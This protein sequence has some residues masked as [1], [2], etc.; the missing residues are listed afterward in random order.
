MSRSSE[1]KALLRA[2]NKRYGLRLEKVPVSEWPPTLRLLSQQPVEV[3]RS[4]GYLVQ[5][6]RAC[7]G[8]L[9]LSICTTEIDGDRWAD[10]ISWRRLQRLKAECGFGDREAVEIY[11]PDAD[12]VDVANMRHLW[13]LPE[14]LPFS[15]RAAP[16]P[17]EGR[18]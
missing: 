6:Y 13:V 8:V 2:E 12:V 4:R 7:D 18:E 9:R 11:P 16:T 3:W 15:W 17:G 5:V 14:R 1:R 10:G